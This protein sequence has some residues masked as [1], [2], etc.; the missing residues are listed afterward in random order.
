MLYVAITL[1]IICVIL[2]IILF[3]VLRVSP[4]AKRKFEIGG[5]EAPYMT[6]SWSLQEEDMRSLSNMSNQDLKLL[7]NIYNIGTV[8]TIDELELL[9]KESTR[10][11]ADRL[12]KLEVL[13][14]IVRT[15]TG[16]YEIT[17]YG[18]R[19][20]ESFKEKLAIRKREEELLENQ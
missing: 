1:L 4:K 18:R 9:T 8:N 20:L 12:R 3:A 14:L 11:L 15:S 7:E 10:V 5:G 13:G 19:L 16:Q 6:E 2:W 17:E